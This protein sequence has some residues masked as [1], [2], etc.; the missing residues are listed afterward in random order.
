MSKLSK[1]LD[2]FSRRNPGQAGGGPEVNSSARGG[3]PYPVAETR[4][5][6]PDTGGAEG[7]RHS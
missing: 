5:E 3:T 4:K 1:L 7:R 2:P 6:N